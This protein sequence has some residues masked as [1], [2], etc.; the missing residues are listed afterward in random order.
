MHSILYCPQE[1]SSPHRTMVEVIVQSLIESSSS[2]KPSITTGSK[3]QPSPVELRKLSEPGAPSS[4]LSSSLEGMVGRVVGGA[5][6]SPTHQEAEVTP[7]RGL[8]Q[9]R[10][11]STGV[12]GK[13]SPT[14]FESYDEKR[15][16]DNHRTHTSVQSD[17]NPLTRS[18]DDASGISDDRTKDS[19]S[20]SHKDTSTSADSITSEDAKPQGSRRSSHPKRK[21]ASTLSVDLQAPRATG[22]QR[23]GE[24]GALGGI[25]ATSMAARHQKFKPRSFVESEP[26]LKA[27]EGEDEAAAS[28]GQRQSKDQGGA[29]ASK[30]R[31]SLDEQMFS[32]GNISASNVTSN[33]GGMSMGGREG[34][35]PK[36]RGMRSFNS[37]GSL[38][39]QKQTEKPS[40]E[41]VREVCYLVLYSDDFTH[42]CTDFNGC[43]TVFTAGSR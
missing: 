34:K 28:S 42:T 32:R 3:D 40:V 9:Q 27:E 1:L 14:T 37:T 36:P 25:R 35:P 43:S 18:L 12:L 41:K 15:S 39:R 33:T 2:Q 5:I 10:S 6:A 30:K 21:E 13:S 19:T 24:G 20:G 7:R 4:S 23:V 26:F 29:D 22:V 31:V 8:R 38:G 11:V 16:R 17:D